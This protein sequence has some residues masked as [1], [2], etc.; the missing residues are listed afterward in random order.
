M[1]EGTAEGIPV[2]WTTAT[3]AGEELDRR[4]VTVADR[5]A[6]VIERRSEG[7]ALLPEGEES[8]TYIV[9]LDGSILVAATSSVGDTD[10][11]RDQEILDR[12]METL[13]VDLEG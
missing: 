1:S 11:D 13:T 7:E 4:E 10:H 5:D 6:V 8:Y 12:M 3:T 2:R 9:D